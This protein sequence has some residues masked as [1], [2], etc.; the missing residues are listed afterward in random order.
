MCSVI[1]IR[2]QIAPA[3]LL[4]FAALVFAI[5]GG[6]GATSADAVPTR[7]EA[8]HHPLG[9]FAIFSS[10]PLNNPLV[11]NCLVATTTDGELRLG[12]LIVPITK[13][14]EVLRGGYGEQDATDYVSSFFAPEDAAPIQPTPLPVQ[15]GLIGV[16]EPNSLPSS[17][18]VMLDSLADKGLAGVTATLEVAGPANAIRFNAFDATRGEGVA[19][20]EPLK[21]KLVSPFLG[22]N[23]YI[24][25][26]SNPITVQATTGTTSPPPPN[27]PLEGKAGFSNFLEKEELIMLVGN[28]DVAN[29]FAVPAASGCGGSMAPLVDRAI[30]AR[31]GL[32]S[33]AGRNAVILDNTVQKATPASV[34]SHE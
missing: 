17:Q 3:M 22:E 32:P 33:P 31:V 20:E 14:F 8:T 28:V 9:A 34:M 25:S 6:A 1:L 4:A 11:I 5:T 27:K 30:D 21:I 12:H 16:L 23:C 2:K 26:A 29:S 18:R 7:A 24:G 19:L 13:T 10:C 15:G